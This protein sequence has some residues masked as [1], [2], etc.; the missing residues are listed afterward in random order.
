[1]R[2]SIPLATLRC[3]ISC[4]RLFCIHDVSRDYT[5]GMV[6]EVQWPDWRLQVLLAS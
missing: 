5:A 2:D 3:F 4:V 6:S 1:M